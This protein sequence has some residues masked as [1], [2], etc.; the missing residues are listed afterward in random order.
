MR[1][2]TIRS[3]LPLFP[4]G[5]NLIVGGKGKKTPDGVLA[6]KRVREVRESRGETREAFAAAVRIGA[7]TIGN[8]E[9]GL[10]ELPIWAARLIQKVTGV[11]AA[12]LMGLV[13]DPD[14]SLLSADPDVKSAFLKLLPKKPQPPFRPAKLRPKPVRGT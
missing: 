14:E 10:R 11:H 2:D 12:Y 13:D 5:H 9:Q 3:S 8:Y 4:S 6:G 1:T 7:S